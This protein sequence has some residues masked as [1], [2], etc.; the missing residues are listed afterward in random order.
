M[1][2]ARIYI[3]V[4]LYKRW[5]IA[6]ECLPTLTAHMGMWDML[7]IYNDSPDDISRSQMSCLRGGTWV[8]FHSGNASIGI[9]A[10]R[11]QHFADFWNRY[12]KDGWTHLLLTDPD[13][14]WDPTWRSE[15]LRIQAKY[16][17]LPLCSYNT[18][19]HSRLIGNTIEDDPTSEVIIRRVAPGISYL[20][21][22]EHVEIVM[23]HLDS[24]TNFDWQIPAWLGSRFAVTRTSLTEHIGVQGLHHPADAG[25][26][27]GDRATNPTPWLVKKRA[28]IVSQLQHEDAENPR[29]SLNRPVST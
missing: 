9:E 10:Q 11:K 28:E 1:S 20:L 7:A 21:T 8:E 25:Y 16:D 22:L 27:G 23:K 4:P 29:S 14:V 13:A 6:R 19:A 24:M 2:E 18:E 15:M 3:A 26:D 12:R 5:A 17:N